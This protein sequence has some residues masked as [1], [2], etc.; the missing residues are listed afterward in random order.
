MI[1]MQIF[2]T[3]TFRSNGELQLSV[4]VYLLFSCLLKF[5]KVLKLYKELFKWDH[6]IILRTLDRTTI[7]KVKTEHRDAGG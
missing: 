4:V 1:L 7:N 5:Y 6:S 2:S 3:R